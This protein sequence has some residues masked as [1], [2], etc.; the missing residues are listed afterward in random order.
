M[1]ILSRVR[2]FIVSSPGECTAV[3]AMAPSRCGCPP[4][5][6]G[7]WRG[8]GSQR[9]TNKRKKYT[10]NTSSVQ[11][12]ICG[13]HLVPSLE[14]RGEAHVASRAVKEVVAPADPADTA[15]EKENYCLFLK[16]FAGNAYVSPVAVEL[17][18]VLVVE[19][20]ALEAEVLSEPY[21]ALLVGAL[22]SDRL[23]QS[24]G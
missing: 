15:T 11:P 21:P 7:S 22:S 3:S 5:R 18:L 20:L 4:G 23:P 24:A 2:R 9:T 16:S 13:T 12:F 14:V 1:Y 10:I 19:E 17:L 8:S 6:L